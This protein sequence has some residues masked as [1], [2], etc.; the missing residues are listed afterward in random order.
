MGTAISTQGLQRR[1]RRKDRRAWAPGIA[2]FQPP[3]SYSHSKAALKVSLQLEGW[4]DGKGLSP[5][6]WVC[7]EIQGIPA[8]FRLFRISVRAKAQGEEMLLPFLLSGM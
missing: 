1:R 5:P 7:E 6:W 2:D 3:S 4:L 8:D